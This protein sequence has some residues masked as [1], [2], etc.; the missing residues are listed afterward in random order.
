MQ[1]LGHIDAL[2]GVAA[3]AVVLQ[4]ATELAG[5][6]P[7]WFN[8]GRFGVDLFFLVSGFV[9]PFSFASKQPIRRFLVT[10]FFRL[11]PAFW[12]SLLAASLVVSMTPSMFTANAT[13]APVLFG[14]SD[15]IG[16]YWTLFYELCFYALCILL[17]SQGMKTWMVGTLAVLFVAFTAAP[18]W[19]GNLSFLGL[20]MCGT[21]IRRWM[22]EDC[23]TARRWALSALA[24]FFLGCVIDLFSD[25]L[26]FSTGAMLAVALFLIV[27]KRQPR[28]Q[29]LEWLGRVSYSL[30][31]FQ[32]VVVL[33]I[34]LF[35]A[36]AYVA[37]ICIFS[38]TIA[39]ASYQ[40]IEEPFNDLGRRLSC[41]A[42]S[43]AAI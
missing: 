18:G 35:W 19:V 17:F 23:E 42:Q 8:L 16:A 28:S 27:V 36:P 5:V 38:I 34:P 11:Y 29:S 20:M 32:G 25:K 39:A 43:P 21:L 14:H 4:H 37:A 41:R 30:Y 31:L 9:I 22:L 15:A 40:L 7:A 1:R 10:R 26:W 24:I 33:V 3:F 13:M 2:R 12:V 6:N